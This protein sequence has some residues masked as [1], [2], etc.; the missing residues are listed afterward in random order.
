MDLPFIIR[1][2]GSTGMDIGR[3]SLSPVSEEYDGAFPFEGEISQVAVHLAERDN[4][5]EQ[6]LYA[7]RA[8]LAM[9]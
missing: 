4:T 1:I 9:E 8:E 6:S 3:D 7:M 2:L 5:L